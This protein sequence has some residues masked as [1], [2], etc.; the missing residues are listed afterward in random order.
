VIRSATLALLLLLTCLLMGRLSPVFLQPDSLLE[1]TRHMVEVGLVALT[2]TLVILTAGIDLSPGSTMGLASVVLGLAWRGGW[3]I[4]AAACAALVAAGVCGALNG[5]LVAWA[6]LPAL[7][8]TVATWKIYHG[9]AL[10]LGRGG[11]VSGYPESFYMLGQSYI[12]G[13]VPAQTLLFA[14]LAV[15]A[16]VFLERTA[17]GRSLRA[18]GAN[19]AGARLSGVPTARYHFLVYTLTGLMAGLAAV[20][21]AARVSTAKA[22]AGQDLELNAITAVVLGGT[23]IAGGEGG[24]GGTVLGLLLITSLTHGL[25]LARVP[26][27]RQA[28]LLGLILIATVWLDRRLR[29][30]SER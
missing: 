1:M 12:G 30:T 29:P 10:G 21:Y 18:V 27:D 26:S 7:I 2:M 13:W 16:A 20:I 19:E 4:S 17:A 3:P 8:V 11:D 28:V 24:I 22:D 14:A 25:T 5:A 9:L 23:S 6:R 15:A